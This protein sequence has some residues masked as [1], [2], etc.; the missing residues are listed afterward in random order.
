M[1][2]SEEQRQRIIRGATPKAGLPAIPPEAED[3][4]ETRERILSKA[5]LYEQGKRAGRE[6]GRAEG[7]AA[8]RA[9][10]EQRLGWLEEHVAGLLELAGRE[11]TAAHRAQSA[12]TTRVTN[13]PEQAETDRID[14]GPST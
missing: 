6:E 2:F 5:R 9:E 10:F 1:P 3:P 12:L 7:R 13:R 4:A 8:A 14:G 11:P